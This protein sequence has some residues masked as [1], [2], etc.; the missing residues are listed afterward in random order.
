MSKRCQVVP[1]QYREAHYSTRLWRGNY[2]YIAKNYNKELF[3]TI[4]DKLGM[5]LEYILKDNNWVSDAFLRD[6][7]WELKDATGDA[8]ISEKMGG[9]AISPEAMNPVE[10]AVNSA[11]LFPLP[12]FQ[13]DSI[14][15]QSIQ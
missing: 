14:S 13:R 9:F 11:I 3:G 12:I 7:I 5:P 8:D 10:Y 2:N 6:F 4:C 1:V 15:V